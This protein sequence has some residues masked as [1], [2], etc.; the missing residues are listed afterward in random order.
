MKRINKAILRYVLEISFAILVIAF[1]GALWSTSSIGS[2]STTAAL[3]D[4]TSIVELYVEDLEKKEDA[5]QSVDL[6][7]RNHGENIDEY[8]LAM[9]INKNSKLDISKLLLRING[10]VKHINELGRFENQYNI[11]YIIEDTNL[12]AYTQDE[13]SVDILYEG[14]EIN[15]LYLSFVLDK[16]QFN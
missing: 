11:F 9:V 10:E 6:I 1:T 13:I 14:Q 15:S 7:V 3:Y 16:G 8:R 5:L 4:N 2:F 12:N